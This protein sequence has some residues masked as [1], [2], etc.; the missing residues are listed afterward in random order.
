[1]AH[2][3]QS[4]LVG[5][6][7]VGIA[8]LSGASSPAHAATRT[9]TTCAD[10]GAG[11]LRATVAAAASGDTVDLRSLAC[12][13]IVLTS[14][15]IMIPQHSLAIRG[16]G[17]RRFSVSGNYHSSVFRHGGT[18]TLALRGFA[19]EQGQY[20][21]H[22]EA[23]GGCIYTAGSL[24]GNDIAVRHCGAYA[25]R[26]ALGGGIYAAGN[27]T[28]F[29]S[30]VYS[31][32]T[33]GAGSAGGGVTLGTVLPGGILADGHLRAHRTRFVGNTSGT[34]GAIR[35]LGGVDITYSTIANN[36][37]RAA[38]GAMD[39]FDNGTPS[40]IAY[41]TISGNSADG[42]VGAFN[43]TNVSIENTTISGN[44]S[45]FI[46]VGTIGG[47]S[48]IVNSTITA[49]ITTTPFASNCVPGAVLMWN[50]LHVDSSIIAHNI[51]N[52]VPS[53]DI[54]GFGPSGVNPPPPPSI[55][56]ADNLIERFVLLTAVPADTITGVDPLLGPLSDN[57]G[58][59][60]THLPMSNSLAIDHGNNLAGF[61]YDQRGAGFPRTK[62]ARTD[63]GAVE[64]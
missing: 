43:L 59:T 12:N 37:A 50:D 14:G 23:N 24:D 26:N 58:R 63:I 8:A 36:H 46:S 60:L 56:G 32:G 21:A 29:Y 39:V 7:W 30:A 27:V 31:N 33:N 17:V 13:R 20:R 53:W 64:R 4:C 15:A 47:P 61:E 25:V 62:G 35:A 28:L 41:S 1:M 10:S 42:Q 2:F 6:C 40:R 44:R 54:T 19:I 55:M 3:T 38:S 5:A 22:D 52:G 45:P 48:S 57:G 18:G 11:S 9:V 51:C 34:A 49:N 16:P